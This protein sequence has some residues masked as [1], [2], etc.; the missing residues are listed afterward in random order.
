MRFPALA[1]V[2]LA[3]LPVLA[4]APTPASGDGAA[5]QI[6]ARTGTVRMH[7]PASRTFLFFTPEGERA[8]AGER[9]DPRIVCSRSG[10]EEEEMLFRNGGHGPLWLV[11]RLDPGARIVE[12]VVVSADVLTVLHIEVAALG[13][14]ES[15]ATVAYEWIPR[16]ESGS[17]KASEHDR[18]FTA[19]LESWQD[20][21]NAVLAGKP[22]P[23]DR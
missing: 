7:G 12:Y 6:H 20:A 23:A 14:K 8:W 3:M 10:K 18:R 5:P 1:F 22:A 11:T 21:M 17:A 16:T 9:W 2:I 4:A 19:T 15:A 13:E